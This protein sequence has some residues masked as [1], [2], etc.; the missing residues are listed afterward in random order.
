M[1]EEAVALEHVDGDRGLPQEGVGTL[2][3]R[4]SSSTSIASSTGPKVRAAMAWPMLPAGSWSR[5]SA[6]LWP[7][8]F[9]GTK[10]PGS[11]TRV[12]R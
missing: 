3:K 6:T 10:R 1:L 9:L 5:V 11:A 12:L 8:V 2:A 4:C 7:A